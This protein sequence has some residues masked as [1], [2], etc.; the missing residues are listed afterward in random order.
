MKSEQAFVRELEVRARE[1]KKLA[2]TEILPMWAKKMGEWLV[3][4]PWRVV[5]PVAILG[6]GLWRMACG[7]GGR[8][9]IL[10]IFGGF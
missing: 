1:Q 6:Y 8:E 10:A 9:L 7:A 2:E 4:H 5:V 3:V